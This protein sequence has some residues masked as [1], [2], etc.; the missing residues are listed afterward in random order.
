MASKLKEANWS[1]GI[2]RFNFSNDDKRLELFSDLDCMAISEAK[3]RCKQK[4][5][6]SPLVHLEDFI[7]DVANMVA[8]PRF[9]P[10]GLIA[11]K[12]VRTDHNDRTR[13]RLSSRKPL[14]MATINHPTASTFFA[15]K[16]R[17]FADAWYNE[18]NGGKWPTARQVFAGLEACYA[19]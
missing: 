11:F 10:F 19:I 14:E 13:S 12:V 9:S 8:Y 1:Y 15:K 18:Y 17:E 3:Q 4:P 2:K 6:Q 5:D 16:M 7:V